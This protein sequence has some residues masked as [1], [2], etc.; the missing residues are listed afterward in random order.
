MKL[1]ECDACGQP[2]YFENTH[3]ENCGR[4]L[5][6]LPHRQDMIAVEAEGEGEGEGWK[7]F[8]NPNHQSPLLS[9]RGIRRLQL[10]HFNGKRRQLL[11]GVPSQP[12]N[13]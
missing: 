7:S 8:A 2:L 9:Q 1:F 4:R 5:G 11:L 12:H 13:S 10:A 3:C 6:F